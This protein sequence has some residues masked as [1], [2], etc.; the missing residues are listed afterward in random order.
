MNKFIIKLKHATIITS[1]AIFG[2]YASN[3]V[4]SGMKN[5]E[6]QLKNDFQNFVLCRE[7]NYISYFTDIVNGIVLVKVILL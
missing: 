6:L 4:S 2:L 3:G 5:A 7:E 1:G